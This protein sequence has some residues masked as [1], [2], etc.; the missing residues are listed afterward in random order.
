MKWVTCN[1]SAPQV[2]R[3]SD[4]GLKEIPVRMAESFD[5]MVELCG[6]DESLVYETF[7]RAYVV[8]AQNSDEG[9]KAMKADG[10]TDG[11]VLAAFETHIMER[12]ER[13]GGKRGPT[14]KS[15]LAKAKKEGR[16]KAYTLEELQAL[17][18]AE[19]TPLEPFR[20]P[21]ENES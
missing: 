6:G 7:H 10:S 16:K 20:R 18:D 13:K 2:G 15:V 14:V 9:R 3:G 17:L 19:E 8:D 12:R 21:A 11:A 5:D 4:K 1:L